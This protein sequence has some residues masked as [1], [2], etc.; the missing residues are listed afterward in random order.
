VAVHQR[1]C[2]PSQDV[3][4]DPES[5]EKLVDLD[6]SFIRQQDYLVAG[7]NLWNLGCGVL[8]GNLRSVS[9]LKSMVGRQKIWPMRD[10]IFLSIMNTL[11]SGSAKRSMGD[12]EP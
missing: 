10:R 7:N 3:E 11:F 8:S 6:E 1:K 12:W 4:P 2:R 9:N 5:I